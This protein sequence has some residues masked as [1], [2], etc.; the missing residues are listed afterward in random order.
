[1]KARSIVIWPVIP[2]LYL[3][4]SCQR[5]PWCRLEYRQADLR[6]HCPSTKGPSCYEESRVAK[7]C[8]HC[9]QCREKALQI[10]TGTNESRYHDRALINQSPWFKSVSIL[11]VQCDLWPIAAPYVLYNR[12]QRS[13]KH[14][15]PLEVSSQQYR[16][17]RPPSRQPY[18]CHW[19]CQS[20]ATWQHPTAPGCLHTPIARY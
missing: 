15:L 6:S 10:R 17:R 1:V 4:P 3:N 20:L 5:E 19:S 14:P 11:L 16:S 18:A 2:I 7:S 8:I 13:F 9:T 12:P